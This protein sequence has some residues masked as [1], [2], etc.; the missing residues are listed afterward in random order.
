MNTEDRKKIYSDCMLCPRQCHADRYNGHGFCG[1]KSG[2][3]LA[4]AM[5]HK[6]EEPCLAGDIGSG[7]IFFSG[8]TLKCVYCQNY[9]ISHECF[10]ADIST[11]RLADIILEL[12][13]EGAETVEFITASQ[14]VPDV[15]AALDKVKHKLTVPAVFNCGGYES[16]DTLSMLDGY[17]DVYLPDI[18]YLSD[19]AAVRYSSAPHYF[20]IALKAVREMIRQTGKPVFDEGRRILRKGV[21]IRHLVLPNLRHDSIELMERLAEE[22]GTDSFLISLMSQY[23]PFYK[24]KDITGLNRRVTSF[25]YDS[26]LRMAQELG[27]N[28]YMQEKSSAKEEYTPGFD[29]EGVLFRAGESK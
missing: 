18:K 24:A 16:V 11:D 21:M 15:I 8:C 29:L 13:D 20:D 6:W 5:L 14:Y 3:R 17:I 26:V 10:G 22:L 19:A 25:E 12:Q 4:K 27:L 1:V 9:D 23:T 7:A 2:V 28:G